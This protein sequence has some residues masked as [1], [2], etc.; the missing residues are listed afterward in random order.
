MDDSFGGSYY[1]LLLVGVIAVGF[2]AYGLF[3]QRVVYSAQSSS[4]SDLDLLPVISIAGKKNFSKGFIVYLTVFELIYLVLASSST[5]LSFILSLANS[6]ESVGALSSI[7]EPDA[8]I[9]V[10]A[11]TALILLSQVRPFS[12]FEIYLRETG[13]AVSGIPTNVREVKDS[14]SLILVKSISK[15]AIG[16]SVHESPLLRQFSVKA[17]TLRS[18]LEA[19][20]VDATRAGT[21]YQSYCTVLYLHEVTLGY[22]GISEWHREETMDL[23]ER[24]R[25]INYELDAMD[26]LIRDYNQVTVD[27]TGD[28][29][30]NASTSGATQNAAQAAGTLNS[31]RTGKRWTSVL[32]QCIHLEH[33]L[34]VLLA[35]FF[36]NRPDA[37]ITSDVLLKTTMHQSM[38]SGEKTL[39]NVL[40]ASVASGLLLT[41]LALPVYQHT[42][43]FYKDSIKQSP[44]ENKLPLAEPAYEKG[45]DLSYLQKFQYGFSAEERESENQEWLSLASSI[46]DS[47]NFW[48]KEIF[49][50]TLIFLVSAG[51]A[52]L[53]RKRALA[54]RYW[55]RNYNESSD[56]VPFTHYLLAG[57]YAYVATLFVMFVY[58]F[59]LFALIPSIKLQRDFINVEAME[60]LRLHLDEIFLFSVMAFFISF[61]VCDY[62]DFKRWKKDVYNPFRSLHVTRAFLISFFCALTNWASKMSLYRVNSSWDILHFLVI[63]LLCFFIYLLS[64]SFFAWLYET[65]QPTGSVRHTPGEP[66]SDD[67]DETGRSAQPVHDDNPAFT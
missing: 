4:N 23:V 42:V 27:A 67:L 55:R 60:I 6:D 49:V 48:F 14:I 43:D 9:P 56:R 19:D 17:E 54:S 37:E 59:I 39:G 66:A 10:L 20:G 52:L 24:F 40:F 29:Q 47:L 30:S 21:M 13:H 1:A 28:A 3:S 58:H 41:L 35:L 18:K 26:A 33:R 51:V 25:S 50:P 53:Y 62:A 38:E 61:F 16:Q 2:H 7:A 15:L 22:T 8:S 12:S 45:A 64:F 65:E 46:G 34:L 36:I 31:N 32:E 44:F 63:P 5:L 57:V 11:S